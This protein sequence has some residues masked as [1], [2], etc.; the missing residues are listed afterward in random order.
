MQ[1]WAQFG[2]LGQEPVLPQLWLV[3]VL[4]WP[5]LSLRH[6][7]AATMDMLTTCEGKKEARKASDFYSLVSGI[8]VSLVPAY[9]AGQSLA[10]QALWDSVSPPLG[11]STTNME[12]LSKL[13]LKTEPTGWPVVCWSCHLRCLCNQMIK[14][15][16]VRLC[17]MT[18]VFASPDPKSDCVDT[19]SKTEAE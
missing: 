6:S 1:S 9:V 7:S 5:L 8:Y 10:F 18:P 13:I 11:V 2:D 16:K 14:S 4:L 12:G 3:L 17:I 19:E 15:L